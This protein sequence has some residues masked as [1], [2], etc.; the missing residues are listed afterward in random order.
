ML[1]KPA[2]NVSN[3]FET[4]PFFVSTPCVQVN[5]TCDAK[6]PHHPRNDW[7][8]QLSRR[9]LSHHLS[10]SSGHLVAPVSC[11]PSFLRA[12]DPALLLRHQGSCGKSTSVTHGCPLSARHG[13]RG[14]LIL[15]A[16]ISSR[17][18][19]SRDCHDISAIWSSFA[20]PKIST[21][22]IH[23]VSERT[24]CPCSNW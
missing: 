6:C 3:D 9:Q 22:Y 18:I 24:G 14:K 10:T 20:C 8:T 11:Q 13:P 16:A 2:P 21:W 12:S 19:R 7:R 1:P 17:P 15:H 23:T 4:T 5:S